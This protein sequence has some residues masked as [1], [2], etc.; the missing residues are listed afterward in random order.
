MKNIYGTIVVAAMT[1]LVAWPGSSAEMMMDNWAKMPTSR[2]VFSM[3]CKVTACNGDLSTPEG[4]AKAIAWW[5]EHGFTKLWLESYRHGESASTERLIEERDAF[6]QAGFEVC[7]MI[8]PTSLS[9]PR[10][11]D[12]GRKF[13]VTCWSDP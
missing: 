1:T 10:P 13:W 3:S 2:H 7:G 11:G 8:T 12:K 4:R 9:D 5:K 6:R